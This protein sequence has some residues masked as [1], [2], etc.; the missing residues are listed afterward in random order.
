MLVETARRDYGVRLAGRLS[1]WSFGDITFGDHIDDLTDLDLETATRN[2]LVE[3]TY[4]RH[5]SD[6]NEAAREDIESRLE[7]RDL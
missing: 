1:R 4:D 7:P 5:L 2:S 3:Y 6:H